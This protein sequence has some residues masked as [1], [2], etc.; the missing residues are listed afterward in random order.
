MGAIAAGGVR[1]LNQEIID[2]LGVTQDQ[3]EDALLRESI[4]LERQERLYCGTRQGSELA[5]RSVV[6]VDD[7]AATG[8]T[9]WAAIS[10]LRRLGVGEIIAA[11]PVA[12]HEAA[13]TLAEAVDHLIALSVPEPF[14]AVGQWYEDF[15]QTTDHEVKSLLETAHLL[16]MVSA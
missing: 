8:A 9:M 2:H 3:L 5:G 4:E 11:L 16:S 1:I 12:A 15:S 10:V 7:G 13:V 14:V 6:V